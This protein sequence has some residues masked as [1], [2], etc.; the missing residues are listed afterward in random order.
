MMCHLLHRERFLRD[1]SIADSEGLGFE[2]I[3]VIILEKIIFLHS[4]NDRYPNE[5][6][7]R[8]GKSRQGYQNQ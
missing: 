4:E 2:I 6:Y 3:F 8:S 7:F 1:K 5:M